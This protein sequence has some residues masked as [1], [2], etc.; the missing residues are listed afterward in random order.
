M[1][2]L[3]YNATSYGNLIADEPEDIADVVTLFDDIESWANGGITSADITDGTIVNGDLTTGTLT[4]LKFDTSLGDELGVNQITQG[5]R[6]HGRSVIASTGTTTSAS[7]TQ[8]GTTPGTDRDEVS[9]IY[10]PTDGLLYVTF[11]ALSKISTAAQDYYAAIFIGANQLK[12]PSGTGAPTVQE[13]AVTSPPDTNYDWIGTYAGGLGL[14]VLATG[15][16]DSTSV[17]TGMVRAADEIIIEGLPGGTTYDVSI[18]FKVTGGA[19]L[20]V[21][22]R[23]L[24]V[25]SAG[26]P[27]Q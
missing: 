11:S 19:T 12:S 6:R 8:L 3:T 25:R 5:Y 24:Y 1:S 13:V 17:A 4:S 23:R 22:E 21:A 10:V 15:A 14:A 27:A 9:S 20:T 2:P 26:F 18:R 7:Y 16:G